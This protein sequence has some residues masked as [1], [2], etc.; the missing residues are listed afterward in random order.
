MYLLGSSI[1]YL[2]IHVSINLFIFYVFI[3]LQ[4][5]TVF[6]I[7]IIFLIKSVLFFIV[8]AAYRSD[9]MVNKQYIYLMSDF[10][11]NTLK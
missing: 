3:H 8:D 11:F 2:I 7:K 10:N 6:L 4:I 9:E 5:C 1:V